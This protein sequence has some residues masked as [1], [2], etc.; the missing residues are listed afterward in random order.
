MDDMAGQRK[1]LEELL[2][3]VRDGINTYK[4]SP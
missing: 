1:P 3:A 4:S 2:S